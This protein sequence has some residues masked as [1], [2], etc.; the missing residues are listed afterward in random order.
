M[1]RASET[2]LWLRGRGDGAAGIAGRGDGS[3]RRRGRDTV[4]RRRDASRR[5]RGRE[6][7]RSR[8]AATGVA[9]TGSELWSLAPVPVRVP[10]RK[11]FHHVT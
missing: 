10:V 8:V 3:R 1:K 9:A 2:Y 4:S 11:D 6:V 7:D 5:R